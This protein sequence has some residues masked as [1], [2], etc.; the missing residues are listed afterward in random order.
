M[1]KRYL[2][3]TVYMFLVVFI[4]KA[5]NQ[6]EVLAGKMADKMKDSLSLTIAQRSQ[7]YQINLQLTNDKLNVRKV[8]QQ[9]DSLQKYMQRIENSRDSLYKSVLNESQFM[10]YKRRKIQLL[11]TF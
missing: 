3:I 8:Y 2:L 9:Q 1:K 4:L 6:P 10:I 7:L 11:N 5:Q